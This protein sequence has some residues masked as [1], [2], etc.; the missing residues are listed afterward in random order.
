MKKVL[1]P[2]LVLVWDLVQVCLLDLVL[3]WLLVLVLWEPM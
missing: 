2:I 1:V 3:E